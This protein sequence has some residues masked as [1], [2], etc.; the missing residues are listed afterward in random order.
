VST[1]I[2]II[3]FP[4]SNC[5]RDMLEAFARHF[6][7]DA[8][9]VWHSERKLP[10]VDG[11]VIPGGFSFG[12]YLRSGALASHSA[13]MDEV[14]QFAKKG[15]AI[16]GICNGFQILTES[17][18]LPGALLKNRGRSFI[19]QT[20]D[21]ETASGETPYHKT[22]GTGTFSM[23][24]A[25]GEGRYYIDSEGLSRLESEGQILLR[26][27]KKS[28]NPNG[29]VGSIAG[30]TSKNGRILGLMPHPERATD[31]VVGGSIDGL[32][33]LRGFLEATN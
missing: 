4:G 17:H 27:S 1:Q 21:L 30:I 33:V 19:C 16:L 20:C 12:D 28:D 2:A 5:D 11:V 31:L 7:I 9:V 23:P 29:S 32:T 14:R 10:K 13:I 26:Y 25:H 18:L 15:G 6:Q 22:L 3:Q 8:K 24:I